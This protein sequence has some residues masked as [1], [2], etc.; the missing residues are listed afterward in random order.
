MWVEV[1]VTGTPLHTIEE[2]GDMRAVE[3]RGAMEEVADTTALPPYIE[4]KGVE[5]GIYPERPAESCLD[6]IP[7]D[8][9]HLRPIMTIDGEE[10]VVGVEGA[11]TTG[12]AY[13]SAISDLSSC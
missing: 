2:E 13:H 9:R 4:R 3:T 10:A 6:T 11:M 8:G 12:T 5:T 1:E 7:G